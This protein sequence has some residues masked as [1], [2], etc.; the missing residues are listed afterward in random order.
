MNRVVFELNSSDKLI[1][2]KRTEDFDAFSDSFTKV[3]IPTGTKGN[4]YVGKSLLKFSTNS[5]SNAIL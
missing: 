1:S 4:P 3:S 5:V 2:T